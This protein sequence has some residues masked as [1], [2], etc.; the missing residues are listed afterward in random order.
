M[1]LIPNHLRR[2]LLCLCAG[3]LLTSASCTDDDTAENNNTTKNNPKNNITNNATPVCG[4][5]KVDADETCD[6]DCP[7][8]AAACHDNNACTADTLSGSAAT[9]DAAC[10]NAPI[11]QCANDDG[12]CAPGC[13]NANDNDCD[14]VLMT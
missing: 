9:C 8:D 11:T 6:G 14:E 3:I 2:G 1:P 7:A 13:D 12:C 4:D 5:G 10:A